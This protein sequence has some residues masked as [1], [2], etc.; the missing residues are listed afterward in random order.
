MA[1]DVITAVICHTLHSHTLGLAYSQFGVKYHVSSGQ[2][3]RKVGDASA[4]CGWNM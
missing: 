1:K 4:V 3:Q 2:I